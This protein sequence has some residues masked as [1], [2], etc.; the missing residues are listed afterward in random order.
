MTFPC[1][2]LCQNHILSLVFET[3]WFCSSFAVVFFPLYFTSV[4]ERISFTKSGSLQG[5]FIS[6]AD[7]CLI[8]DG[9]S[10]E[11]KLAR[12]R[13][14]ACFLTHLNRT[15]QML[16]LHHLCLFCLCL[17]PLNTRNLNQGARYPGIQS[18]MTASLEIMGSWVLVLN[19]PLFR[20]AE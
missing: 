14:L 6:Q 13:F 15:C 7:T 3:C 5:L 8:R 17:K 19:V 4:N 16:M 9:C 18:L 12:K 20:G 10:F 1:L 11:W 2:V